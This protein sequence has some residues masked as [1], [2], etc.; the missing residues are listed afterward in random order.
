MDRIRNLPLGAKLVLAGGPLLFLNLSFTWQRLEVDFGPAGRAERLLD[1]W[2]LLGLLVG[3]LALGLVVYVVVAYL[4][5]VEPSDELPWDTVALAAGAAV[6]L[7]TV[8]KNLTD[9]GS[10]LPSYV[11]VGLAAV[12]AAGVLLEWRDAR[13][14]ARPPL[15]RLRTRQLSRDA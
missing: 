4:T 15:G 3:V 2:D 7:L 1:G 10:T 5:D 13:G 6:F 8:L 9:A 11:G 12:V 14:E